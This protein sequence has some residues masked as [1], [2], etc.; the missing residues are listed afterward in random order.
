MKK[1]LII[2]LVLCLSVGLAA[3]KKCKDHVDVDDDYLCDNCGEN[4]DDGDEVKPEPPA[5]NHKVVFVVKYSTGEAVSGVKFSLVR[6]DFKLDLVSGSDGRAEATLENLAYSVDY[7][8]ES[9]PEYCTADITGI[10]I[11]AS[12]SEVEL[13]IVDN[14]PDGSMAKPFFI[15][16]NLTEVTLGAGEEI[17]Y[18]YKGSSVKFLSVNSES[19]LVS[20]GGE[21]YSLADG[22]LPV[23][24]EPE[25]GTATLF[26]VKN[27]AQTETTFTLSL[28]APEGSSEN[29]YLLN[30]NG[31]T[32][33]VNCETSVFYRWVADKDGVL[34]L[35]SDDARNNISV[36]KVLEDDVIKVEQT[37]GQSSVSMEVKEGEVI[38]IGVSAL[39]GKKG[40]PFDVEISFEIIIE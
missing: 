39:E 35:S 38:T 37:G 2:I 31:T 7:D 21:S 16:N 6:G 33:T 18:T 22:N 15:V 17:Y 32:V 4:F 8:Y 29:P 5:T 11:E 25:I 24:I 36:T 28:I 40:E 26:S 23:R 13:V 19:V 12:T 10:K 3:C 30:G 27:T 34:T 1:I 14:R 20:L 9:L